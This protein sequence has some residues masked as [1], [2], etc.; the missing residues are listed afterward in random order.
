VFQSS[1]LSEPIA[2]SDADWAGDIG[3]RK[4]IS[5]YMFII[6]GG[7]VS[8]K[9]RKQDTVA[10]STAEAEYIALSSAA[11]EC[12][13]MRRLSMELGN[14]LKGPTIVREDNQSCIDGKEPSMP[15]QSEAHRHQAS[16]CEETSCR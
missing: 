15:W 14:A 6:A 1:S 4:S 11:Q 12:V 10:L 16:F 13:W 8:W 5:G 9:S 3:N 2:Y 7:P